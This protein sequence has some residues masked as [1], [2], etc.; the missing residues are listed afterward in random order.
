TLE[1]AMAGSP[2]DV[3]WFQERWK[4]Y[5]DP[6]FTI[7]DWLGSE[8]HGSGK[9]HRGLVWLAG[10]PSAWRLPETWLH[11]DVNYEVALDPDQSPP[12]W[13]PESTRRHSVPRSTD[14]N[15]LRKFIEAVDLAAALPL[16]FI[17]TS[18]APKALVK[19]SRREGIPLISLTVPASDFLS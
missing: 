16:D 4:V 17:I 18:E 19:A 6:A 10:A 15:S 1:Q 12:S 13:L 2:E 8:A 11:P 9:P 5:I 7:R 14:R 3:F